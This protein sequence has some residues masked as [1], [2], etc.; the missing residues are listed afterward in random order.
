MTEDGG[1]DRSLI[2]R[3]PCCRQRYRFHKNSTSGPRTGFFPGPERPFCDPPTAVQHPE[4]A[5]RVDVGEAPRAQRPDHS[6]DARRDEIGR[7]HLVVFDV[8]HADTEADFRIQIG[9]DIQLVVTSPGKFEDQVVGPESVQQRNQIPPESAQHRLSAIIAKTNMYR[10]L[11]Q[12]AVENAVDGIDG[13]RRILRRIDDTG[14]VE[15][16]GIRFDDLQLLRSMSAISMA[17]SATSL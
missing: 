5:V 8:D 3:R 16:Y 14:L 10:L 13:P 15:L 12:N 7:F 2:R 11:V 6:L 4:S 9:E 1:A 17:R